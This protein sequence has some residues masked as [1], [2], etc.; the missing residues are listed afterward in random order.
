MGNDFHLTLY[1]AKG[2][3]STRLNGSE[4]MIH[5]APASYCVINP[6]GFAKFN[7]P[8]SGMMVSFS[9]ALLRQY[10][11]AVGVPKRLGAFDFLP[12]PRR[13][14][15]SLRRVL[16]ELEELIAGTSPTDDPWVPPVMYG[17]GVNILR[18]LWN[19]HPSRLKERLQQSSLRDG[20]DPRLH[21]A[22]E[23]W[24]EHMASVL[25]VKGMARACGLSRTALFGLFRR[26]VGQSPRQYLRH[27]RLA[28]AENLLKLEPGLKWEAVAAMVGFHSGWALKRAFRHA[29]GAIPF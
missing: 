16:Q 10:R 6:N 18:E 3:R 21:Q 27:L 25:N 29:R 19:G 23:Y 26:E 28:E 11:E 24:N 15:P 14:A 7:G 5:L 12:A 8:F 2:P 9:Q 1:A 17:L 22:M 13:S 4:G 20:R